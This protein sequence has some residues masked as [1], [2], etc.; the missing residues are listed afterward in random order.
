MFQFC[1]FLGYETS[2]ARYG[3]VLFLFYSRFNWTVFKPGLYHIFLKF[4]L[5]KIPKLYMGF[6][7]VN[8]LVLLLLC[9]WI[10]KKNE[11]L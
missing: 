5:I 1:G 7:F 6:S 3:T 9:F 11:I 8:S 2:Y 10:L 4:F